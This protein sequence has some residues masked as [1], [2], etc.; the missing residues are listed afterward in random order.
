VSDTN[1]SSGWQGCL[2]RTL[3]GM[4]GWHNAVKGTSV[5]NWW[6]DGSNQ[7]AFG[8]GAKGYVAIN[9]SGSPLSRTFATGLPTGTYCDVISGGVS[10]GTCTGTAVNVDG[11]GNA[12]FEV[13]PGSAVAIDVA[14]TGQGGGTGSVRVTFNETA[15]TIW[16]QNVFVV[17]SIPTLGSWAPANAVALSSANYPVWS[18]AVTLPT[19][20]TFQYKYLKK[21][22]DG[23]VTWESDPNR[24][25][26]TG[27]G[28]TATVNDTWR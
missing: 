13:A 19:A 5:A 25:Y 15:T 24:T 21:N 2:D 3:G 26:T 23:S 14:A 11:S 20:T 6:S 1:C 28:T 22:T 8:R 16:G 27:S 18:A 4:V 7:I 9:N 12:T 17:G 10:G